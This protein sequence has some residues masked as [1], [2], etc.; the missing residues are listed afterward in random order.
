[1]KGKWVSLIGLAILIA[2]FAS[3]IIPAN[4]PY[5][6]RTQPW[7]LWPSVILLTTGFMVGTVLIPYGFALHQRAKTSV[8]V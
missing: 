5:E 1:M 8:Q 6:Q 4:M 3:I 2:T 7:I